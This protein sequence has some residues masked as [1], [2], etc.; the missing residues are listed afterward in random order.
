MPDTLPNPVSGVRQV[1]RGDGTLTVT[2]DPPAK[3]GSDVGLLHRPSSQ[4]TTT[5]AVRTVSRSR[6]PAGHRRP[7]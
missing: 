4:D 2:W 5:G 7:G 3:K 6:H 1:S